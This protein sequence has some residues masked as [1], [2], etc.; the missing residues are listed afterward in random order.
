M[1]APSDSRSNLLTRW[2]SCPTCI[3]SH[4]IP[5]VY[6]PGTSSSDHASFWRQGYS[7]INFGEAYWGD[8][9]NPHY[10]SIGDRLQYFNLPYFHNLAK[11]AA[12]SI[13]LVAG[14]QGPVGVSSAAGLPLTPALEQNYP[15]PFNPSTVN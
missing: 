13:A 11:L 1:A 4:S 15:N 5:I 7:A 3:N 10:H 9:F 6:V 12:G 2:R 8:D 14:I